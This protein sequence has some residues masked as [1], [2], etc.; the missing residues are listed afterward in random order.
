MAEH[1]RGQRRKRDIDRMTP[2][3]IG[4]R[5]RVDVAG[6]SHIASPVH[7]SVAVEQLAVAA[8]FANAKTVADSRNWCTIK[9]TD[10]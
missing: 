8:R 6:I 5:I 7:V 4:R 1:E 10:D 2:A 3:V 9:D